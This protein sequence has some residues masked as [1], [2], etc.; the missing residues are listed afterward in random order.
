MRTLNKADEEGA[1]MTAR[2]LRRT[3]VEVG[4]GPA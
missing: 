4:S 1:A 3:G 2:S